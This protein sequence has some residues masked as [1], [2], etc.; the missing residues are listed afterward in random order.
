[1]VKKYQNKI[2]LLPKFFKIVLVSALVFLILTLLHQLAMMRPQLDESLLLMFVNSRTWWLTELAWW[3]TKLG[4]LGLAILGLIVMSWLVH[5]QR[6]LE[7]KEIII[8]GLGGV[9]INNLLKF[10]FWRTRPDHG[11]WLVSEMSHSFP[12]GHTFAATMFWGF[13]AWL[14]WVHLV[15]WKRWLLMILSFTIIFIVGISRVYLGVHWPT[16]VLAG[17]IIG[18][19]WLWVIIITLN[20]RRV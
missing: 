20:R 3:V 18:A 9:L 16:D 13:L 5:K 2:L 17:W 1:M 6:A 10:W 14:F 12:S 8:L 4:G 11:W 7:V 19:W 15:G